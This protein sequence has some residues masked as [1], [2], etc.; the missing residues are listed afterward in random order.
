[1]LNNLM[2]IDPIVQ[3]VTGFGRR[4]LYDNLLAKFPETKIIPKYIKDHF[5][6]SEY[7]L[8][9]GFGTSVWFWASFLPSL[10]RIDGFDLYQQALD[11]AE[12]IIN[13][14]EIPEGYKIAHNFIEDHF[15]LEDWKR[16][17]TAKGNLVIQDYRQPW[18]KTITQN[19]YD[20]ITEYGGIGEVDSNQ[21]FIN[22][23]KQSS[24]VLKPKGHMMFVNFL[25]KKTTIGDIEKKLRRFTPDSLQL[26]TNLYKQ[27]T[28]EA[29][30]NIIDFHAV[31]NP[32][33]MPIIQTFFY[34]Y[35]QI[36]EQ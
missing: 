24:K 6:K 5:S 22:I 29:G 21:E 25:E 11:E 23:I 27:A 32:E 7:V 16:L 12:R 10:K 34:G 4:F 2:N 17:K 26:N 36:K 13:L 35:A 14:D 3:Y 30:M 15:S 20:L 9:L 31:D 19:K 28:E 1:M 18:P 33:G 8:D